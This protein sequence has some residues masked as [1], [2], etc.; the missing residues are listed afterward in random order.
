MKGN[1]ALVGVC[2]EAVTKIVSAEYKKKVFRQ[3]TEGRYN[4]IIQTWR[5]NK[6][7]KRSIL[8]GPATDLQLKQIYDY[9]C[10]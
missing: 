4:F 3:E 2:S 6:R 9:A 5:M 8:T 1:N 10:R 7:K